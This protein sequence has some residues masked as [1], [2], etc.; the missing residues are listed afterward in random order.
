M[1]YGFDGIY[2]NRH[3]EEARSAVSKDARRLSSFQT[4]TRVEI[5]RAVDEAVGHGKFPLPLR[6]RTPILKPAIAAVGVV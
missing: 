6:H 2:E 4:E 3:P 1:T 5:G